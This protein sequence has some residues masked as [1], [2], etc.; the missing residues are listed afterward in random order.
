MAYL[1]KIQLIGNCGRDPEFRQF[2]SGD[3]VA[4]FSLAV[5]KRFKNREGEVKDFTSW[6]PITVVGKSVEFV[7]KFI[8]KGAVVY[9]EG[10][11][12]NGSYTNAQ[13]VKVQTNEVRATNI[14]LI[15][16]P[17]HEDAPAGDAPTPAHQDAP[18]PRYEDPN[19]L[20]F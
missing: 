19:D 10:E 7:R 11:S 13:G 20:P 18:A 16:R 4:S 17:A 5:T 15:G 9:V 14:Q 8:T 2:P 6:F 12:V 1:N 3:E